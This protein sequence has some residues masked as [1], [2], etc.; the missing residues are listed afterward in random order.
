MDGPCIDLLAPA[1]INLCLH[2]LGRRPDGYRELYSL[3]CPVAL[4]DRLRLRP[5][6]AADQIACD[7][8]T[9][10]ADDSNL[11]LKAAKLFNDT[12]SAEGLQ[13]VPN[14]CIHLEKII[15]V[16]AG[17]GGGSS[18]AAAVLKGLNACYGRPFDAQR[19]R[20]IALNLGADV[21]FFIDARPAIAQGIGEQL[22]PYTGLPPLWAVLVY[23]GF[24]LSTVQVYKGLNLALTKS[25][26]KL[27]NLP[28]KNGNFSA[29]HHLHNDLEAG[30]G[31]RFPVIEKVKQA[32]IDQG[33]M[34]SLMTGSGS[35]VYGLFADEIGANR[36]KAAMDLEPMPGQRLFVAR[37]L[38]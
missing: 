29:T 7:P 16:G 28:F 24:A 38:V 26:K 35:V 15:P 1:K 36:A 13:N 25:K 23:P 2:V 33:A 19:L 32:L 17:L 20:A 11:A 6:R 3:M 31:D 12:L 22:T 21:P 8:P 5:G 18:D 27:R 9:V 14:V 30:V 4:Y 37:L 10:R 34:A